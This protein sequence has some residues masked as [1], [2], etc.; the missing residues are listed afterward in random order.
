MSHEKLLTQME[1][2]L[3]RKLTADERRFLLLAHKILEKDHLHEINELKATQ[4]LPF[5][6]SYC[7]T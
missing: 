7:L 1:I 4:D 5:F 2:A 3:E 6:L